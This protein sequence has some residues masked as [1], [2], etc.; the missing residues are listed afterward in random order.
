MFTAFR[1]YSRALYTKLDWLLWTAT[2]ADNAADFDAL[3]SPVYK[4]TN[5]T[6]DR[7]PL[8][9]FYDTDTGKTSLLSGPFRDRRC[10]HQVAD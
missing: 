5:E 8:T 6:P 3:L 10:F 2:L 1:S 7:V 4:F 9:D